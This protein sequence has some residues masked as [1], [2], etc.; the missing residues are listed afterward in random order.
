MLAVLVFVDAVVDAFEVDSLVTC[1]G[2]VLFINGCESLVLGGREI[3]M[4]V[5]VES[6]VERPQQIK[7]DTPTSSKK[8]F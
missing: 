7:I 3:L 2:L 4:F 8:I 1:S 5:E 6:E